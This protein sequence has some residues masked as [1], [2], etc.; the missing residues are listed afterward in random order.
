M[1]GVE[2]GRREAF[3]A[4]CR[5]ATAQ[6]SDEDPASRGGREY[7]LACYQPAWLRPESHGRDTENNITR[8]S[9][10]AGV[11]RPKH[12]TRTGGGPVSFSD[13]DEDCVSMSVL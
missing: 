11:S 9:W 2:N 13:V 8:Q 7:L 4:W 12:L 1:N 3:G 5:C 10:R 6:A